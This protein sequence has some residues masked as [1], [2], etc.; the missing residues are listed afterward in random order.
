VTTGHKNIFA[1]ARCG[2]D[3]NEDQLTELLAYLIQPPD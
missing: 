2:S 3:D 1:I